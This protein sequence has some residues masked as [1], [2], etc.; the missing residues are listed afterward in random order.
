MILFLNDVL[1]LFL[2]EIVE[3]QQSVLGQLG[4]K[5]VHNTEGIFV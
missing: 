4:S 3:K 2:C 5:H 1:I